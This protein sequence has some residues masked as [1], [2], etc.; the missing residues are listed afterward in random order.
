MKD[1]ESIINKPVMTYPITY[2]NKYVEG[3]YRRV[4]NNIEVSCKISTP[5]SPSIIE[6]PT[7]KV[8][9]S[10]LDYLYTYIPQKPEIY[11]PNGLF[12]NKKEIPKSFNIKHISNIV[13]YQF[14]STN[15]RVVVWLNISAPIEGWETKPINVRDC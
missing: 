10:L 13:N 15:D 12:L 2:K 7:L 5:I 3:A 9:F 11:L 8:I 14:N 6:N 1:L 4:G